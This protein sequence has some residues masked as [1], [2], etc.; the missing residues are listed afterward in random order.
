[1]SALG[2]PRFFDVY[3]PALGS[4]IRI[5]MADLFPGVGIEMQAQWDSRSR[6]L[7]LKVADGRGPRVP[8]RDKPP[9]LNEPENP[10]GLEVHLLPMTLKLFYKVSV[11][12]YGGRGELNNY[13]R[14]H[15]SMW[16]TA[17]GQ[18]Q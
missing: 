5:Q 3:V 17:A 2:G 9:Y 13:D 10:H 7:A 12:V 11:V 18:S 1:M 16:L 15:C 14:L 4:D 8:G 6:S